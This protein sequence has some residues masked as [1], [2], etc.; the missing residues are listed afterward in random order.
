MEEGKKIVQR[1]IVT[2]PPMRPK[3]SRFKMNK[4]ALM[5]HRET[6]QKV[7]LAEEVGQC[8]KTRRLEQREGR[9]K[10]K[11][12]REGE[13]EGGRREAGHRRER[14]SLQR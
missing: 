6:L 11:G 9:E 7:M 10:E 3:S 12:E 1:R 13:R 2:V 8:R 4:G 5:Q 14:S